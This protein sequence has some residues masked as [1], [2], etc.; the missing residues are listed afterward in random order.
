ML[1]LGGKVLAYDRLGQGERRVCVLLERGGIQEQVYTPGLGDRQELDG[2]EH[3]GVLERGVHKLE[4]E[5]GY[6]QEHGLLQH[7]FQRHMGYAHL[8]E[9]HGAG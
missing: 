3:G 9:Q 5:L 6:G 8:G 1:A 4:R 2:K 7:A